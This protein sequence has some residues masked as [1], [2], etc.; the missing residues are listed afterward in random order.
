[1]VEDAWIDPRWTPPQEPFRFRSALAVPLTLGE[2]TLGTLLLLHIKP[3]AFSQ[4]QV[5][6]VEA[7]AR[8]ISIALNNA[9][10]FNL[11]RDQSEHLGSMLREQQ[12]EASRSRAILEAVTDG[13]IVT[14][15]SS[16][17][18]LFNASAERILDL[19]A[20]QVMNKHLDQ[21]GGLFGNAAADWLHTIREWSLSGVFPAL[22]LF[23][24]RLELDN[25]RIVEVNLAPVIMRSEFLGT[26]SVF[27]DVTH[28][29]QV[30]RLKRNLSPTSATSCAPP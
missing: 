24:E 7:A 23:A 10:L 30:D 19:P 1:M 6:L 16:R 21:Y 4:D 17:I 29:V 27:R 22:Q 20:A 18:Y 11:I 2:D 13:I 26:V 14:D 8:Q 5:Q 25:G 28:E 12:V 9:E 3:D 15:A